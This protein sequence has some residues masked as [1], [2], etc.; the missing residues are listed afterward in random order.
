[1]E[2]SE[3]PAA[4]VCVSEHAASRRGHRGEL[5]R[6]THPRTIARRHRARDAQNVHRWRLR[7]TRRCLPVG[8]RIVGTIRVHYVHNIVVSARSLF[9]PHM[10]R[11][12]P[13]SAMLSPRCLVAA[14]PSPTLPRRATSCVFPVTQVVFVGASPRGLLDSCH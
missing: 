11:A 13:T 10:T 9:D 7:R 12:R 5:R 6:P 1:V 4:V 8:S 14:S 3:S 2:I